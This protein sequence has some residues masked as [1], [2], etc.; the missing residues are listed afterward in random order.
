MYSRRLSQLSV[1]GRRR[2]M[3]NRVVSKKRVL[4]G[5]I[6]LAI[7]TGIIFIGLASLQAQMPSLLNL[8]GGL[9]LP[10]MSAGD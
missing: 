6:G 1:A 3:V 2:I 10:G 4:A 5:V 9:K 8:P 7:L